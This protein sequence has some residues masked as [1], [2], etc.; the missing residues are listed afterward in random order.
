MDIQ[1][2]C[3]MRKDTSL[4]SEE[5]S[6]VHEKSHILKHILLNKNSF[7]LHSVWMSPELPIFLKMSLSPCDG[8]ES[9]NFIYFLDE[10]DSTDNFRWKGYGQLQEQ[11][12]VL[13]GALYTVSLFPL[14]PLKQ[15]L[16]SRE[17]PYQ[18]SLK[19]SY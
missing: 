5:P 16:G 9:L 7:S 8:R 10:L 18:V 3:M 19:F 13:Q 2:S 4:L 1:T 6:I 17:F 12:G 15:S 11:E 14:I